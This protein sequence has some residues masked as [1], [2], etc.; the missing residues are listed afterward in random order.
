ME[1]NVTEVNKRRNEEKKKERMNEQH[2]LCTVQRGFTRS[3]AAV[4]PVE[5]TA[6]A[7]ERLTRVMFTGTDWDV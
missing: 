7:A 6:L 3:L 5:R 1:V 4:S 2:T